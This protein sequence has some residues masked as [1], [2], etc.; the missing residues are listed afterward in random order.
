MLALVEKCV[1]V[2][3]PDVLIL[4]AVPTPAAMSVKLAPLIAGNAPV[5]L[6]AGRPVKFA[7]L[8]AGNVP[9]KLAA[10]R[11]VKFAPSP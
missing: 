1:A 3:I 2:I 5:K 4:S 6:A 11:P 7:P 10:G 8:I 9:V